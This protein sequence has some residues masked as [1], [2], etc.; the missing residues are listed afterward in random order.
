MMQRKSY[1]HICDTTHQYNNISDQLVKHAA[2]VPDKRSTEI[3]TSSSIRARCSCEAAEPKCT[4]ASLTSTCSHGWQSVMFSVQ[5]ADGEHF[6]SLRWRLVQLQQEKLTDGRSSKWFK[7]REKQLF[8]LDLRLLLD[9]LLR[10]YWDGPSAQN[11]HSAIP[12]SIFPQSVVSHEAHSRV[13][14]STNRT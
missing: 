3:P 9:L 7:R 14:V 5:R 8:H 10:T 13:S 1:T 12:L 11:K 4:L 6:F 2:G